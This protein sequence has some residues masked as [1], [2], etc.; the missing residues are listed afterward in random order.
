MKTGPPT[1]DTRKS[2]EA[3]QMDNNSLAHTKRSCKYHRV[4]P[5]K[6][7]RQAIYQQIPADI[8][9]IIR[10]SCKRKDVEIIQAAAMKD[11]I[12][13]ICIYSAQVQ[14]VVYYRYLKGKSSLTIF[15]RHA[16][17]KYKYGNR[18]FWCRGYYVDTV[19][20]NAKAINE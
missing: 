14:C 12:H 20:R 17:L 1:A 18:H 19:G 16:K 4:F 5:P 7:R 8:G 6:Y 3:V 9:Q 11:H 13:L 15:D 2:K 10:M